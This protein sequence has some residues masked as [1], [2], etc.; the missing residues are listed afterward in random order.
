MARPA[1][2]IRQVFLATAHTV[3]KEHGAFT[4]RMV[5]ERAQ[6]GYDVARR[7]AD[8]CARA[9]V[10]VHAGYEKPA[11]STVWVSMYEMPEAASAPDTGP[12]L[13]GVLRGWAAFR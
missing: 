4:H 1:G 2:E 3:F 11:G 10:L 8:N 13:D 7:T 9:G 12:D 5:A 6:I